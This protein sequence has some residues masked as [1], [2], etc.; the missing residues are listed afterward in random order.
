[1][2]LIVTF[3][4][5]TDGWFLQQPD[6]FGKVSYIYRQNLMGVP[7]QLQPGDQLVAIEG[8]DTF[9]ELAELENVWQVGNQMRYTVERG[10][11]AHG[12]VRV[13]IPVPLIRWQLRSALTY[14][15][16]QTGIGI[17]IG[18][19]IFG[20]IALVVFIRRPR[21]AAARVMFFYAFLL[22]GLGTLNG[23][24]NSNPAAATSVLAR[25]IN[26]ISNWLSYTLLFPPGL[27]HF[28]LVFPRPKPVVLRKRYLI[29]SL[30]LLGVPVLIAYAMTRSDVFPYSWMILSNI[31]AIVILI[32]SAITM[33]DALSR[34]QLLWGIWGVIISL[35][36]F[37]STYLIEFKI[38]TGTTANVLGFLY[39]LSFST[40]GITLGIAI[41]RYRLFDIDV[42]I[43][44]TL[45]YSVLSA[46]LAVIYLGLV[47]ALQNAF[48]ALTGS[49]SQLAIVASTLAIATLFMPLRSW[50]QAFIDR[51]F[52]RSK[53]NAEQTLARFTGEIRDAVDL[54]DISGKLMNAV[55]ETLR[56]GQ[57]RLW[58]S[59]KN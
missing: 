43:R 12:I 59:D 51:R 47:A 33:R 16:W 11:I 35:L 38:V 36:F 9:I 30:Y 52:Y 41:L 42:I 5:P 20:V 31:G 45:T 8:Y 32:H 18:Q 55:D 14:L 53:Y 19:L 23:V 46:M 40:L 28:A 44:R 24:S 50:M 57:I 10:G 4:V 34:V 7:S 48:R 25:T 56:P 58:L 13:D 21:D 27:L 26:V 15:V 1:M 37:I 2:G 29:P 54:D 17:L 49:D 3:I 6:P 39:S 22:L